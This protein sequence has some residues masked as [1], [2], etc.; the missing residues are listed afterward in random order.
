V[1]GT[2]LKKAIGHLLGQANIAVRTH[3]QQIATE[4]G[5]LL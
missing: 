1:R 4:R 2:I 5:V 3:I